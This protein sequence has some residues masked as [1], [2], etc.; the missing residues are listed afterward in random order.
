MS[1]SEHAFYRKCGEKSK[2]LPSRLRLVLVLALLTLVRR[3]ARIHSTPH[4]PISTVV[5]L[6]RVCTPPRAASRSTPRLTHRASSRVSLAPRRDALGEF[7]SQ[8]SPTDSPNV[9]R[10]IET[11]RDESR[12]MSTAV[13]RDEVESRPIDG[14]G[15]CRASL[16]R[17]PRAC[18][19]INHRQRTHSRARCRR[20]RLRRP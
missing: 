6:Q 16:W 18:T 7:T 8:L 19:G 10:S 9:D 13:S 15:R 12:S 5:V 17:A 2:T 11:P 14:R 4:A 20:W 1:S 3:H